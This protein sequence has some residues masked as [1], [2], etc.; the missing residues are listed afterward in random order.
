M[1]ETVWIIAGETAAGVDVRLFGPTLTE[2]MRYKAPSRKMMAI[3][4]DR[5]GRRHSMANTACA[6]TFGV[7]VRRRRGTLYNARTGLAVT[8]RYTI[9]INPSTG[10]AT[11][12]RRP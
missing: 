7:K 10:L 9:V 1:S 4:C 3:G 5:C 2:P 12:K 8:G 11:V 6:G